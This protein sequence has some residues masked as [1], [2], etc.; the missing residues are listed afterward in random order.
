MKVLEEKTVMMLELF[1][2]VTLATLLYFLKELLV[3]AKLLSV[4]IFQEM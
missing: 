3:P 4:S 1:F 2:G